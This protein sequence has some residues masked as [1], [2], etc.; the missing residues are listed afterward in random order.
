MNWPWR[1]DCQMKTQ[2]HIS[3]RTA[4]HDKLQCPTSSQCCGNMIP[5]ESAEHTI[6]YEYARA[7]NWIGHTD[8]E[9][10]DFSVIHKQ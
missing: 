6:P 5:K 9:Q 4:T 7:K 8:H 1:F 10:Q 3:A 2:N